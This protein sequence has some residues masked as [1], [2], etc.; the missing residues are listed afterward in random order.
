MLR[1]SGD[2][3]GRV[4]LEETMRG[5]GKKR[6]QRRV[7]CMIR[8]MGQKEAWNWLCIDGVMSGIR[9]GR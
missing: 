6:E 1:E 9:Q 7:V 5:V 8:V 2:R 3:A 4:G